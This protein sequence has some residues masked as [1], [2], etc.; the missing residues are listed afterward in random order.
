MTYFAEII[1]TLLAK[2][3]YKNMIYQTCL[4]YLLMLLAL[5]SCADANTGQNQNKPVRLTQ[6]DLVG[7][8]SATFAGG[9]FW[10]T[11]A[12]FERVKG[13]KQVISGYAGGN[14]KN[15]TYSE[16][17]AGQSNHAESIMV[18]YDPKEISYKELLEM[19]FVAHD[20][21]TLN[22]QGPDIGRQY[23]SAIFYHNATQQQ[24]AQEY[25]KELEASNT[26]K[27][28]IVTEVKPVIAFW[29]AEDYHQDYYEHHPDD[30]YIMSVSAP[31]VNKFV[32]HF[33]AKLKPEFQQ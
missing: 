9:C 29:P 22:R 12:S 15:P 33:K 31:K 4:S 26:F 20:P 21:T 19:F 7:T 14:E 17:S 32:K 30:P 5:Y 27:S 3:I 10:C 23:R 6:A 24:Q 13:V 28:K 1:V 8:D 16:V 18:Y 2:F 11:E 25:I